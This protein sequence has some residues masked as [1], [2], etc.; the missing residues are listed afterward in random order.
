MV[1]GEL[2]VPARLL[3]KEAGARQFLMASHH[4]YPHHERVRMI[5]EGKCNVM[6][7]VLVCIPKLSVNLWTRIIYLYLSFIC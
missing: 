2:L 1:V 6:N 5:P 3:W 7:I 4:H